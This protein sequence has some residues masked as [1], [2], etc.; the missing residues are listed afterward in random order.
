MVRPGRR[1]REGE[2][3]V[4]KIAA[5]TV[6]EHRAAQLRAL[7][8]AARELIREDGRGLTLAAVA[9]RAG[10]AR[11]SIYQYFRS[12]EEMLDAVVADVVPRWSA[13]ITAAVAGAA[14]HQD[15][16]VAY[17]RENL[18]L[19]AEG[20]HAVVAALR[21]EASREVLAQQSAT[22]HATILVA[23]VRTLEKL[24]V[25]DEGRSAE[26]V[27][28]VVLAAA[29]QVE[30]GEDAEVTLVRVRAVLSCLRPV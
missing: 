28:A 11:S 20:E 30:A 9:A 27:N 19:V 24:G 18:L 3:I 14:S 2:V 17:A 5:P 12:R 25:S 16:I 21:A 1:A 6:A 13:R 29:R 23:L 4:P 10:L 26:L 7:L 15:A 8:D 22:M